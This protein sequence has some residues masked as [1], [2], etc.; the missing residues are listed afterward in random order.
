MNKAFV[1]VLGTAIGAAVGSYVTWK[2][3]D[4]KYR[5]LAEEEIASVR[6]FYKNKIKEKNK[7]TIEKAENINKENLVDNKK[8]EEAKTIM[9]NNN[10]ISKPKDDE[11]EDDEEDDCTYEVPK[12]E[13]KI[14]PYTI[15]PQEYG[16][17]DDY[18]IRSWMYYTD[19]VVADEDNELIP[20]PEEY[21][22]DALTRFG[23]YEDDAV[24]VRNEN[25]KC[26][27]EILMSEKTFSESVESLARLKGD[28]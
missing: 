27:Y 5:N 12:A 8:I 2:T 13:E 7:V 24:Y 22:G 23:E 1:F 25:T 21:I 26:D 15:N 10:Y 9:L 17:E 19:G 3:V 4:T 18:K 11:E 20:D 14:E 16:Y 6:E 28:S